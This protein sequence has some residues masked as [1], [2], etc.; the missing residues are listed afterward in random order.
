[1]RRATL[2]LASHELAA[3]VVSPGPDLRYLCGYDAIALER[4]TALILQADSA[5][6]VVPELEV[7]AALASPVAE[8]GIE[9]LTWGE[10]DDPYRVV[11]DLIPGGGKA[12]VEARMWAAKTFALG[13]AGLNVTT[14]E[15]ALAELRLRKSAYE[16]NCLR[17]AGAAIDRVHEQVSGFLRIGRTERAI[18]ADISAAIIATGHERVDFAIVASGPNGASPHHLASD[19]ELVAGDLIVVDIGG[20]MPDGYCSDSTRTY[21]L[22]DPEPA[23][24]DAYEVLQVAQELAVRH[25]VPGISAEAIDA[26]AR[27]V[28]TA[29]GYGELFMHR[30]GHGIGLETHEE[31][32]LVAGN[33]TTLE[34]G[35]VFSVEPG[36]YLAD[37]F[38]AR[39][40]DIV[41]VTETGWES[42]NLRPR[43]LIVVPT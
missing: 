10:T 30:T 9:V 13:G 17:K 3:L 19:R 21:C 5:Y 18:A 36:I 27:S 22:G 25:V 8:L 20:T 14:G 31:P 40:E 29:A 37:Q 34:P 11:A 1:M 28:I 33:A 26:A 12:G 2:G 23:A 7:R 43:N 39:I 24:R 38:G 4:L 42:F 32:Y 16:I 35:M 15:R 6:L 41:A